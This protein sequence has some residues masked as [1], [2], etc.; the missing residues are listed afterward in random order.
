MTGRN[1]GI[2][3]MGDNTQRPASTRAAL[4]R[5]GTF[6]SC[7]SRH[8]VVA[9]AGSI[10]ARSFI[11]PGGS[12]RARRT[13]TAQLATTA[14]TLM[15]ATSSHGIDRM[16]PGADALLIGSLAGFEVIAEC[17]FDGA[18]ADRAVERVRRG[19]AEVGV[20]DALLPPGQ[21]RSGE[22]R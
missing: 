8:I 17:L 12:L 22:R 14:A 9:Q 11:T 7:R 15:S 10:A 16:L 1:S 3:S 2:K 21:H 5:R 19:V 4:A 18:V 6:G 13:R 20:E